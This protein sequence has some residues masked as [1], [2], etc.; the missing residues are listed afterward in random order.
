MP[1]V[2]KRLPTKTGRRSLIK[3]WQENPRRRVNTSGNRAIKFE[4]A[5]LQAGKGNKMREIK[6]E[7]R[8][9][10]LIEQL[11]EVWESS[12]RETHLFLSNEEIE[13]IREYVP[14]ALRAIPHLIA[15]ND[16]DGNP[17]A[18]MGIDGQKL[19]MLF[20]APK[21]RG[22]GLGR[23]LLEYGMKQY[24]VNELAVNEQ[25]PQARGFYEHLGFKVFKRSE[26]DE[27]GNP[28][29]ILLMRKE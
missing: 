13:A 10:A 12:V 25:N 4:E 16:K 22:N 11:L 26:L 19:E 3:R 9:S 27:Q 5:A 15:E 7:E 14:E 29:P 21:H 6:Q 28:Y 24:A 8:T 2:L 17:A 23:K 18:F 1:C 20:I